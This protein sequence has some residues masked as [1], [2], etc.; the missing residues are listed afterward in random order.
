MAWAGFFWWEIKFK[1][2]I[3]E[4]KVEDTLEES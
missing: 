3:V 2:T 1:I 4:G